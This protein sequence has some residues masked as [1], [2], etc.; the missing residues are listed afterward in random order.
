MSKHL[1]PQLGLSGA[2][3][4][5]AIALLEK[6]LSDEVVLRTKLQKYH[7]NVT[8]PEFH[9]LHET[10]EEQ[11]TDL[12]PVVDDAAER[13]RQYGAVAIGTLA[14]FLQHARLQETPGKNPDTRG[15]ISDIVDDHEALIRALREDIATAQKDVQ[16]VGLEDFFTGLIQTHQKMAWLLRAHLESTGLA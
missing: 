2:Q 6:L 10:F 1:T 9:Q 7:W 15:M 8:G 14:E 5:T 12:A 16:D 11:Y 13:I 4:E 3:L